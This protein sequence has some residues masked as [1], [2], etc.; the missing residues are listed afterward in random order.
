MY[1]Y[2]LR[3]MPDII[4]CTMSS[5]LTHEAFESKSHLHAPLCKCHW[6][7]HHVHIPSSLRLQI[8]EHRAMIRI[9]AW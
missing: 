5:P 2:V 3:N 4:Y 1:V 8:N 6:L 7:I 9:I